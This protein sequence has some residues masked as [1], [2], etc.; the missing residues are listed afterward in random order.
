MADTEKK[1]TIYLSGPIMDEHEGAARDWRTA[2]KG[3]LGK[4]FRILDPM[5]RKFVDR[6]VDTISASSALLVGA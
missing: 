1:M 3:L 5:R 2:A 4:D 6:Q